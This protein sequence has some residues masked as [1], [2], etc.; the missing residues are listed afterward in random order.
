[1][2]KNLSALILGTRSGPRLKTAIPM[3]PFGETTVLNRTL[4]AYLEAGFS[5]V[6]VVLGSRAAE[7]RESLGPLQAR[8]RVV[9]THAGED[10]FA[11]LVRTGLRALS[12]QIGGLAIGYGDQP[13]LTREILVELGEAFR[14]RDVRILVP[15]WQGHVGHPMYFGASFLG[16]LR[17]LPPNAAVWELLKAHSAEVVDLEVGYTA[18]VRGIEDRA[19]Y[20]ELLRMAGLPVPEPPLKEVAAEATVAGNGGYPGASGV[21][22]GGGAAGSGSGAGGADTT[23]GGGA[24]GTAGSEPDNSGDQLPGVD[25]TGGRSVF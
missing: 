12:G 8:V 18:V 4:S 20:H 13:L 5:E 17:E 3:L 7:I 24:D 22:S 19:D 16:V 14:A 1:M 21:A 9:E 25:G 23:D 2:S 11:E 10:H 15:T 6:I